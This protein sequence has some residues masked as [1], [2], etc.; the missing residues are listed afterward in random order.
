[1]ASPA[2]EAPETPDAW[3]WARLAR[4]ACLTLAT[5][6]AL[7]GALGPFERRLDQAMLRGRVRNAPGISAADGTRRML[8]DTPASVRREALGFGGSSVTFGSGVAADQTLSARVGELLS[9]RGDGR[10]VFNFAQSG[11]GPRDMIPVAAAMGTHPVRML[12]V[13]VLPSSFVEGIPFNPDEVGD[14]ELSLL[15]AAGPTQRGMLAEAGVTVPFARR[16]DGALQGGLAS[17]WRA[18]RLRGNLWV[19]DRFQPIHALWSVRRGAAALGVL[20]RRFEGQSTNIG[21]LPWRRAYAGVRAVG[22]IQRVVVPSDRV[23]T[24]HLA[25]LVLLRRMAGAAGVPVVFYVAPINVPFQRAY[26]LMTDADVARLSR[27][28]TALVA[29]M[30]AEGL[31]V[32]EAPEIPEDGFLDRVHLTPSGMRV[33]A[34]HLVRY[35]V[36][37]LESAAPEPPTAL[38][39]R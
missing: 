15:A 3:T 27:V 6:A 21:R 7:D 18:Y 13:E 35:L 4:V 20:P 31:E 38:A 37:R 30:R 1:M 34:E 26:A 9:A 25:S 28:T 11:G 16:V 5:L 10:A 24:R 32:I 22:D 29:R 14:E 2:L 23:H 17:V 39:L 12:L 33:M 36:P 19:D 8:L